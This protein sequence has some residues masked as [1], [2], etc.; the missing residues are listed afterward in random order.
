VRCFLL[1]LATLSCHE[2]VA[3]W[4]ELSLQCS[5]TFEIP[6][7]PAFL[8]K[9]RPWSQQ[10]NQRLKAIDTFS[11][12]TC[13][14]YLA[15]PNDGPALT[16]FNQELQ[17]LA[18]ETHDYQ[19]QGNELKAWLESTHD[20]MGAMLA[21][22]GMLFTDFKCGKQVWGGRQDVAQRIEKLAQET[23][24]I[25]ATC[26]AVG[27]LLEREALVKGGAAARAKI[28]AQSGQGAPAR[29][30]SSGTSP[31]SRSTITGVEENARKQRKL[32]R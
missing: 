12:V 6:A 22:T 5:K 9:A 21:P 8:A 17:K 13:P 11:K 18:T 31:K 7:L 19:R 28:Q 27:K 2:A 16:R 25:K 3:S 15:K 1:L 26:P 10:Y 20:S 32:P 29:K 30:P 14:A 4:D 24:A 23:E